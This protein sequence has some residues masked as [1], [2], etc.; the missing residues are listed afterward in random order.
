MVF[1]CRN[2][3]QTTNQCPINVMRHSKPWN[4][5]KENTTS[6]KRY[7]R[8]RAGFITAA[9]TDTHVYPPNHHHDVTWASCLPT[10][11]MCVHQ[12]LVTTKQYIKRSISSWRESTGRL[13]P[14]TKG[15]WC[16]KL[17]DA[18]GAGQ[19]IWAYLCNDWTCC[20]QG[21]CWSCNIICMRS[22]KTFLEHLS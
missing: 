3:L 19:E 8:C 4:T 5:R 10:T 21:Y 11:R 2:P 12:A 17:F 6:N 9:V 16:E 15:Q 20:R 1:P 13:F 14:L 18:S 22:L 7:S